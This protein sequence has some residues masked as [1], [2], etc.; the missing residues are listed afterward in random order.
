MVMSFVIVPQMKRENDP[1]VLINFERGFAKYAMPSLLAQF[2]TGP[3]L[4]LQKAPNVLD[5]FTVF[6]SKETH[7]ASKIVFMFIILWLVWRMRSKITPRLLAGE[8]GAMKSAW[9]N[10]HWI[11]F[12][13]FSNVFMGLSVNTN[14]FNF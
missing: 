7:I 10:T 9:R 11:T 14:G 3:I 8:D 5:W 6:A 1:K 12:L 13:S 2:L 4:A